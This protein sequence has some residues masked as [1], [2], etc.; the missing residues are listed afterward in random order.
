MAVL[1][2]LSGFR[3]DSYSKTFSI[4]DNAGSAVD[5][6]NSSLTFS[7]K[8]RAQD[9][10][11]VLQRTSSSGCGI[12]ITCAAQGNISLTID[13]TG[14]AGT[15]TFK[16]GPHS[17]DIQQLNTGTNTYTTLLYGVFCVR[18]DITI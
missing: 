8:E 16:T 14:S 10:S 9:V 12:C 2:G 6:S 3:G 11:Y 13:A 5:L 18:E 17:Y 7:L 4:S 1:S 15:C